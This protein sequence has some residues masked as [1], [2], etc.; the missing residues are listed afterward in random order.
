MIAKRFLRK[1]ILPRQSYLAVVVFPSEAAVFQA[2]RLLQAEG[3]SPEHLAIV[4]TGY[5]N[6]DRV[7]LL[8]PM[9]IAVSKGAGIGLLTGTIGSIV[10][11]LALLSL[12]LMFRL[13]I[14]PSLITLVPVSGIIIGFLGAFIGALVGFLG[15]G[16]TSGIYR[17]HLQQGRYLLMIE[18]PERLVRTGRDLLS[19]YSLRSY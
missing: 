15:E 10:G 7:G 12:N 18:G 8:E 4:G 19:Q 3:I 17:H 14:S 5:S 6:P 2:Y 11:F 1:A 9:Q 13:P 16:S